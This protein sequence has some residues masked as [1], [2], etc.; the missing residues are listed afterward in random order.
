MGQIDTDGLACQIVA[1][2]CLL[3]S[4]HGAMQAVQGVL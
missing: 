2:D 4:F 3:I 1:F